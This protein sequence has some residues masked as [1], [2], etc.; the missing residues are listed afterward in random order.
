MGAFVEKLADKLVNFLAKELKERGFKSAV[1]GLSG[2]LDSSVVAV[3][4]QKAL[5]KLAAEKSIESKIESEIE[6]DQKAQNTEAYELYTL[7]MPSAQSSADSIKDALLLCEKFKIKYKIIPLN[8]AQSAL[9]ST[10]NNENLKENQLNLKSIVSDS[11]KNQ[12]KI[13][14][15]PVNTLR[16]GNICARLR[17]LILY[18]FASATNSLVIGTSNLSERNLGY[19]TIFGDLAC[20]INPIGNI[21]KSDIYALAEFLQIPAKI[22]QKPPSADLYENQSDENELGFPYSVLDGIMKALDCG[23]N[24]E[25]ILQ[26]GFPKAA[27]QLVLKRKKSMAFK[28][29]MP[30]IADI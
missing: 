13:A 2:G 14:Q 1:L 12:Q 6:S 17:M 26:N 30:K 18:D 15:S 4:A 25:Q 23:Q 11:I 20:A 22:I 10:I 8:T 7:I 19:G 28:L 5:Q 27:L 21:Y 29:Q 9:L 24:D 16:N 3:L